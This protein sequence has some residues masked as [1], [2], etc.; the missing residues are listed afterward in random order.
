MR[1][2]FKFIVVNN[3]D[4]VPRPPHFYYEFVDSHVVG[5]TPGERNV[6]KSCNHTQI[7]RSVRVG[8]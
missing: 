2:Y 4:W 6:F 3:S 8:R 5:K 1:S 7:P